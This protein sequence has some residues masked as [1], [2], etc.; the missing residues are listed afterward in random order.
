MPAL[1]GATVTAVVAVAARRLRR[2]RHRTTAA[3][4]CCR[5]ASRRCTT[6]GAVDR[7]DGRRRSSAASSR[8]I[9]AA[10][11]AERVSYLEEGDRSS[12]PARSPTT[13]SRSGGPTTSGAEHRAAS[14]GLA[15]GQTVTAVARRPQRHGHRRNRRGRGLPLG[16]RRRAAT[17]TDVSPVGAAP[18][19]ALEYI[20]GEQH[21]RRRHRATGRSAPGSARRSAPTAMLAHGAGA[22]VRAAGRGRSRRSRRRPAT[23][24]SPPPAPTARSSC[25]TRPPDGRSLDAAGHGRRQRRSS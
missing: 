13:R 4:R 5:S 14:C 8:S 11:R 18:I 3:S 2:G 19:T 25:G 16:A 20:I 23:A 10:G 15:D 24:R 22:R 1:A 9:R 21:V 7:R 6:D 12:S 17:L